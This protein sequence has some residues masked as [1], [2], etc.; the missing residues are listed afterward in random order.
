MSQE[1][2][3]PRSWGCTTDDCKILVATGLDESRVDKFQVFFT[4]GGL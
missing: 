4:A 2:Y 3:F 1:I